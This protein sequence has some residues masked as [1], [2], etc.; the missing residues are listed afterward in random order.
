MQIL[1][2]LTKSE[3]LVI[4]GTT[5]VLDIPYAGYFTTEEKWEISPSEGST[6]KSILVCKGWV[7]FNKSTL[8][9]KTITQRSQQGLKE[10]IDIWIGRI[11]KILQKKNEDN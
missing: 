10:D 11:T 9:K 4:L 5:K 7:N 8:M 3:T 1:F 2:F 6:E